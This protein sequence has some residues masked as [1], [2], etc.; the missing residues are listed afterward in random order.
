MGHEIS[1]FSLRL[2]ATTALRIAGSEGSKNSNNER[3]FILGLNTALQI[4]KFTI[5]QLHNVAHFVCIR[6]WHRTC[7][8]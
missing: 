2:G 7:T 1:A 4:H 5:N 6:L 8:T 3:A